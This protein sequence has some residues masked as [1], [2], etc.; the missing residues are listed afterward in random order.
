MQLETFR[1][2]IRYASILLEDNLK[3]ISNKILIFTLMDLSDWYAVAS[4]EVRKEFISLI[5]KFLIDKSRLSLL[6]NLIINVHKNNAFR[7]LKKDEDRID[8][9]FT[10][11]KKLW[12]TKSRI[13]TEIA[14]AKEVVDEIRAASE[15]FND[16]ITNPEKTACENLV[17]MLL[18]KCNSYEIP[19]MIFGSL[20]QSQQQVSTSTLSLACEEEQTHNSLVYKS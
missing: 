20:I 2:V 18:T 6:E 19:T 8:L 17:N 9:E 13:A 1:R 5:E 11:L 3:A 12:K 14:A 7:K 4:P 10:R 15:E 16:Q